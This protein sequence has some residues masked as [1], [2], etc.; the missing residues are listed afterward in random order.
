MGPSLI[1]GERKI[2]NIKKK[3]KKKKNKG[4]EDWKLLKVGV[5]RGFLTLSERRQRAT[6]GPLKWAHST[7]RS[8]SP[9]T[10][11]RFHTK[12]AQ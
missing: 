12:K 4:V 11:S 5:Q 3:E 2:L 6:S 1:L 7:K 8:D 9:K 10:L